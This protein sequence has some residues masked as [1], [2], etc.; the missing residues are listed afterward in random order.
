MTKIIEWY[1][2]YRRDPIRIHEEAYL[3]TISTTLVGTNGECRLTIRS[4]DQVVAGVEAAKAV[5]DM[6]WMD[7]INP[8]VHTRRNRLTALDHNQ[9]G[10]GLRPVPRVMN[11]P[12]RSYIR[13]L[14][15]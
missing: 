10:F 9:A 15:A 3:P 13:T 8:R 5:R 1:W 12:T 11:D 7:H 4:Q 14:T 2:V 6:T